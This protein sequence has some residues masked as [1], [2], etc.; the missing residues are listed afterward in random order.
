M[1]RT[2]APL[3]LGIVGTG[4]IAGVTAAAMAHSTQCRA[5][6]VSSRQQAQADAFAGSHGLALAFGDWRALVASP[7][8]DAVYVATPTAPRQALVVAGA[9]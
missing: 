9:R 6:A 3:R 8:I 5:V 7:D 1:H 2:T 4:L